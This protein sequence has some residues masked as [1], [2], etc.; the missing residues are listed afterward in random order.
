MMIDMEDKGTETSRRASLAPRSVSGRGPT[1]HRSTPGSVRSATPDVPGPSRWSGAQV[2]R[3]S[4]RATM[5]SAMR[6][7]SATSRGVSPSNTRRRTSAT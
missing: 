4:T 3:S 5:R 1:S 7:R 2:L 6:A